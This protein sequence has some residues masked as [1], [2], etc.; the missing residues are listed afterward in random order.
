MPSLNGS[1]AERVVAL[2]A[3]HGIGRPDMAASLAGMMVQPGALSA[4]RR[5]L[6]EWAQSGPD[7]RFAQQQLAALKDVESRLEQ[8]RRRL[9]AEGL[10]K[11][12]LQGA[13]SLFRFDAKTGYTLTEARVLLKFLGAN[14]TVDQ[15]KDSVTGYF[16]KDGS[17]TIW[18]ASYGA[19][20]YGIRFG[21]RDGA[22]IGSNVTLFDVSK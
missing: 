10:S 5:L 9:Q 17:V 21:N 6:D 8:F 20:V 12:A 1:D 11:D 22:Y 18:P 3:I 14:E 19:P 4:P 16:G 7:R 15:S 13:I 2:M